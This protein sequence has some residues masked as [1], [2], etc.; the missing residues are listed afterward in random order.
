M[1]RKLEL[2]SERGT[3]K[4]SVQIVEAAAVSFFIVPDGMQ[5]YASHLAEN[6]GRS[7]LQIR[8]V[9]WFGSGHHVRG[10]NRRVVVDHA[11]ES[12]LNREA[13]E[14]IEIINGR[15]DNG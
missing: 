4:T 6:L 1:I 12:R 8:T 2:L 10:L 9:S 7:D 11:A 15:V 14:V 13:L 5:N 3:G